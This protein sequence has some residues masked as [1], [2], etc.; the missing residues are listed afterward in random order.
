MRICVR[1]EGKSERVE[2]W[3]MCGDVGRPDTIRGRG[4]VGVVGGDVSSLRSGQ[5]RGGRSAR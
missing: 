4:L 1:G 3:L 5:D 2:G